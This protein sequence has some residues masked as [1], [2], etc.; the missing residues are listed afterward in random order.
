MQG[1]SLRKNFLWSFAGNLVN[2]GSQWALIIILAKRTSPEIIGHFAFA[3]ALTTPIML[4]ASLKLRSA[5]AT[6]Q[7]QEYRFNEYWSLRILTTVLAM[8][9]I[10]A[11]GMA[12][13][14]ELDGLWVILLIGAAKGFE[15]L[16]DVIYGLFQQHELMKLIALS[17]I[18]RGLLTILMLVV[19]LSVTTNVVAVAGCLLFSW[20]IVLILFD[21]PKAKRLL[22]LHEDIFRILPQKPNPR[23][24]KL[25][26][27]TLPL[28]ASIAV[29]ALYNNI[30]RYIIEYRLGR[31]DLG[32]F[33]ALA[34][35]MLFGGMI[36]T[37]LAQSVIPRLSRYYSEDNFAGFRTILHKLIGM[38]IVVGLC[39]VIVAVVLGKYFIQLFYTLEYTK[40]SQILVLF[41]IANFIDYSF[42][43]IASAIN[44]MRL[45][46]LQVV[47]S[48]ISVL[49]MIPVCWYLVN[50]VGLKG[51][52][53]S[54]IFVKSI[55]ALMYIFVYRKTV[56]QVHKRPQHDC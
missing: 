48:T 7:R 56:A 33:S 39:G 16:S 41:M 38:G 29:G 42:L 5:Q 44:A 37:A 22:V 53:L 32:I 45:F 34:Y 11:I 6:D 36:F 27:L 46:R 2:A 21:I 12:N 24:K 8:V 1:I 49:I 3:L 15:S 17:M 13:S 50:T 20:S 10:F 47:I 55:E 4:F 14:S 18:F 26:L 51:A 28:G 31:A 19:V 30:P 43:S 40:H 9:V 52:A 35:F 54:M 23:L 25:A